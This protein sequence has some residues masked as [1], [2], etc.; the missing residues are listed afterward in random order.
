MGGRLNALGKHVL[1]AHAARDAISVIRSDSESV[2]EV[3]S[4]TSHVVIDEAQDLLGDRATLLEEI[5]KRVPASCGATVLTDD[6]QAIYGFTENEPGLAPG[7]TLPSRLRKWQTRS[8]RE[9][10]LTKVYRTKSPSL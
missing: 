5:L 1:R 9:I 10:E 6:A 8:F 4:E 3:L 7:E 2:L